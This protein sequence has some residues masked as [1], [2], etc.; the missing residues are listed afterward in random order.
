MIFILFLELL[1]FSRYFGYI[2]LLSPS[3]SISLNNKTNKYLININ[4]S[5]YN[6][7][8]KTKDEFFKFI[9]SLANSTYINFEDIEEYPSVDVSICLMQ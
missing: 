8:G 1:R 3:L 5:K 4:C 2:K 6:I 7:T 9:E